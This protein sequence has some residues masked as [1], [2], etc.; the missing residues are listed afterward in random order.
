MTD[1]M[2]NLKAL[3]AK[4]DALRLKVEA[5]SSPEVMETAQLN[6]ENEE[7]DNAPPEKEENPLVSTFDLGDDDIL[8]G[9][10]ILDQMSETQELFQ[11][12]L[13]SGAS[14]FT[15]ESA[16]EVAGVIGGMVNATINGEDFGEGYEAS[17]DF[18]RDVVGEARRRHPIET[19]GS[20]L[21]SGSL[22]SKMKFMQKLESSKSLKDKAKAGGLESLISGAMISEN[23]ELGAVGMSAILAGAFGSMFSAMFGKLGQK[24]SENVDPSIARKLGF[25]IKEGDFGKKLTKEV[26]EDVSKELDIL[27]PAFNKGTVYDVEANEFVKTSKLQKRADKRRAKKNERSAESLTDEDISRINSFEKAEGIDNSDGLGKVIPPTKGPPKETTQGIEDKFQDAHDKI[28][29][30]VDEI[31]ELKDLNIENEHGH[32]VDIHRNDLVGFQ[33][34]RFSDLIDKYAGPLKNLPEA[35]AK[36]KAEFNLMLQELAGTADDPK[37]FTLAEA[38][39]FKKRLY[40]RANGFMDTINKAG[41]ASDK[42]LSE[43]VKYHKDMA[44][45][46]KDFIED[47]T[48]HGKL[49]KVA[50]DFY[51]PTSKVLDK[52]EKEVDLDVELFDRK[53]KAETE[54][55]YFKENLPKLR[56][57]IARL[58]SILSTN[59]GASPK[60]KEAH[61]KAVTELKDQFI[62]GS[63]DAQAKGKIAREQAVKN[64]SINH[65]KT[66]Q[67]F[68][69]Q[70]EMRSKYRETYK[71]HIAKRATQS[72]NGK[73][74]TLNKKSAL[75]FKYR[76]GLKGK[77]FDEW[78]RS[79]D[80]QVGGSLHGKNLTMWNKLAGAISDKTAFKGQNVQKWYDSLPEGMKIPTGEKGITKARWLRHINLFDEMT[81]KTKG[82][83]SERVRNLAVRSWNRFGLNEN[84]PDSRLEKRLQSKKERNALSL[85][86]EIEKTLRPRLQGRIDNGAVE[87]LGVPFGGQ[88]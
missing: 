81:P 21:M 5:E 31:I 39:A 84:T 75:I 49:Q 14:S 68:K 8:G 86:A 23:G 59:L 62:R 2:D 77:S 10:K 37:T 55:K 6:I 42:G 7:L 83:L 29:N 64:F 40:E 24:F 27:E 22:L 36:V 34:T 76:D 30:K 80:D 43:S 61:N 26:Q 16:D 70:A 17:R 60:A 18:L 52:L 78:G 4:R 19:F 38:Q 85:Q 87:G 73:L 56:A 51:Q 41:G 47:A 44:F 53:L 15:L 11:D 48:T 63:I 54:S 50:P 88:R 66:A 46:I 9:Q 35:E 25:D 1:E 72:E 3:R 67:S 71:K 65:P 82:Q 13:I 20:D 32:E 45:L 12:A 74:A 58:K 57:E 28:N 79:A 33:G 69:I